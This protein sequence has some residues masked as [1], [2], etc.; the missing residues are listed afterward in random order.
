MI[1]AFDVINFD[2][3]DREKPIKTG[4]WWS[5]GKAITYIDLNFAH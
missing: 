2:S 3:F 4:S 5:H 1:L